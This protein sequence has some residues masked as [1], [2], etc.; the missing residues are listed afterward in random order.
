L[1]EQ[2]DAVCASALTGFGFL[3][4][5][6]FEDGNGRI[7]RFLI[8]HSHHSL[9]KLDYTPHGIVFPVSAVMLRDLG[10]YD[11][12]LNAFSGKIAPF[13]DTGWMKHS[14]DRSQ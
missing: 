13:I 6:A 5:H 4:V 9:A 8:H 1:K 2:V 3:F 12:A 10:R 7:H 14:D 11:K